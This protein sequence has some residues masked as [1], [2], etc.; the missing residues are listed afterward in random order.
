MLNNTEELIETTKQGSPQTR[1]MLKP[2]NLT[3]K[4]ASYKGFG[5]DANFS[6]IIGDSPRRAKVVV[7]NQTI[8]SEMPSEIIKGVGRT[9][10]NQDNMSRT[11]HV[12]GFSTKQKLNMWDL[13][14][15]ADT[16]HHNPSPCRSIIYCEL[17]CPR[18]TDAL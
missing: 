5:K 9:H 11:F 10:N 15:H 2:M 3:P 14:S 4:M 1:T 13:L 18:N 17:L 8:A 7:G 12:N 16:Y 6:S